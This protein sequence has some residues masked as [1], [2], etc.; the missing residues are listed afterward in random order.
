MTPDMG[1]IWCEGTKECSDLGSGTVTNST[2]FILENGYVHG[3]ASTSL[4]MM[5]RHEYRASLLMTGAIVANSL[6]PIPMEAS[7]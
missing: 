5:L 6:D 4:L 7:C 3:T 2:D 1:E